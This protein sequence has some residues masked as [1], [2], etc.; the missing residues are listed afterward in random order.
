VATGI[1]HC[2]PFARRQTSVCV[3]CRYASRQCRYC[4]TCRIQMPWVVGVNIPSKGDDKGWKAIAERIRRRETRWGPPASN[5]PGLRI[6]RLK[7]H[8]GYR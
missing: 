5:A 7:T 3:T 6:P 1:R 4:P 2:S 8:K